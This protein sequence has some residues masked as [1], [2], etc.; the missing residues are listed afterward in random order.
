[1]PNTNRLTRITGFQPVRE[2]RETPRTLAE[3]QR[4]RHGLETHDT[5]VQNNATAAE[6][7]ACARRRMRKTMPPTANRGRR[8][9]GDLAMGCGG[10]SDVMRAHSVRRTN[11]PCAR[12]R[13]TIRTLAIFPLAVLTGVLLQ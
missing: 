13:C 7:H 6:A 9:T 4:R 8:S 5:N 11:P 1:M 2:A 10:K 12:A 3:V